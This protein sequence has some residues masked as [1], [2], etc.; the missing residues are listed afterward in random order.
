MAYVEWYWFDH[1]FAGSPSPPPI[2]VQDDP[3]ADFN[4]LD[5]CRAMADIDLFSASATCRAPSSGPPRAWTPRGVGRPADLAAVDH[6]PH[7]RGVR[8][9][10]RARRPAARADRRVRR[11]V[12]ADDAGPARPSEIP[13][14]ITTVHRYD[15]PLPREEVWGLISDVSHYRNWWPWLRAFDAAALARGRGMAL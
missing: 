6:D 12:S 1:V 9:A 14:S 7:D 8:A 10:Q 13:G 5:P 3:D 4:D 11:G 15:L 2:S